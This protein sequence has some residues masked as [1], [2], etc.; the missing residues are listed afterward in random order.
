MRM[1]LAGFLLLSLLLAGCDP[2]RSARIVNDS[3]R[4]VQIWE[5]GEPSATVAPNSEF[6]LDFVRFD[7]ETVIELREVCAPPTATPD[8]SQWLGCES[9]VL[10]S[11]AVTWE[12]LKSGD[13]VIQVE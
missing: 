8:A 6:E 12:G 1:V 10:A 4:A 13:I 5:G 3:D 7:G 11:R 2:G 9:S